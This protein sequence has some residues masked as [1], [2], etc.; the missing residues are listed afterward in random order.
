MKGGG[1]VSLRPLHH[2]RVL[3]RVKIVSSS[4][5]NEIIGLVVQGMKSRENKLNVKYK[6]Y[7]GSKWFKTKFSLRT[8]E[9]WATVKLIWL[10]I[11]LSSLLK[12]LSE[13]DSVA[14][15]WSPFRVSFA[16]WFP[17]MMYRSQWD[18]AP[19]NLSVLGLVCRGVVNI[20]NITF[21]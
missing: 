11:P 2:P 5:R 13:L 10:V 7:F 4:P 19:G 12:S 21:L 18:I 20:N 17:R 1:Y 8:A 14:Q 3:K 6:I 16:K 9:Y 15:Y